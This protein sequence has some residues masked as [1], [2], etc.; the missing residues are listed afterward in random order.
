MSEVSWRTRKNI[1]KRD[2]QECQGCAR[3]ISDI[4]LHIHHKTPRSEGGSNEEEN[5]ITLCKDCHNIVH[6]IPANITPDGI[7]IITCQSGVGHLIDCSL[8]DWKNGK[9]TRRQIEEPV[10]S[11]SIDCTS[12]KRRVRKYAGDQIIE[13]ES[14]MDY[15]KRMSEEGFPD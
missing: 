10:E 3:G 7:E 9:R 4:Q 8:L 15:L 6:N 5:L 14:H 1:L 13:R 2:N 11:L 12:C